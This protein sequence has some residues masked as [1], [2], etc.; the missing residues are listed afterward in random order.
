M[1]ETIFSRPLFCEEEK[2]PVHP[3]KID[4][5]RTAHS[6]SFDNFFIISSKMLL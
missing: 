3:V 4:E 5:I 2:F 1:V 6:R